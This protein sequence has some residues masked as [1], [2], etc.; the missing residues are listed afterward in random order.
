METSILTARILGVIYLSFGVGVLLNWN[1]YKKV[2][3]DL[4]DNTAY[5]VLA[6]MIAI[7]AGVSILSF[8]N[9]WSNDWTILITI[10]GWIGTIKGM[11]LL[12][13]PTQ[14]I[15]YRSFLQLD[16]FRWMIV[17]V[18]LSMGTLFTYFGFIA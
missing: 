16:F 8:H 14:M 5:M 1:N 9:V 7:G 13:F 10:V 4:L 17:L 15:I 6:G 11:V 3:F 12:M 2:I 18:A